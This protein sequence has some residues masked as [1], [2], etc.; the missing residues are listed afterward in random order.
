MALQAL[1]KIMPLCNFSTDTSTFTD[2]FAWI[3]PYVQ[4]SVFVV[5][6]IE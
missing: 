5:E 4:L 6:H 1:S 2:V 3:S